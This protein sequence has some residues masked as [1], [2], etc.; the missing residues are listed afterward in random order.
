MAA[1][2]SIRKNPKSGVV[3]KTVS[4]RK[5]L[6]PEQRQRLIVEGAVRFFSEHGL[7]GQLRDLAKS[8]GITHTLMYHYF[9]TK[10]ALIER[11]YTDLFAARWQ[12]EWEVLL[13]DKKLD[14]ETKLTRFYAEYA[15]VILQRDWVRVFVFSGLSDRYIT[16]R[17]FA[18]LGEKLFPRVVRESRKYCGLTLAGKPT[19]RE[20]ELL[21]GLHGSIFYMG[22]RR[23]VYGHGLDDS[24]A[25]DS[26]QGDHPFDQVFIHDRVRGYLLALA[27]LLNAPEKKQTA[28][29]P[30]VRNALTKEVTPWHFH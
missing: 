16:D 10:Q 27:E 18:L 5:R 24:G 14:V 25:A 8:L 19:Q 3:L 7:Q 13:D 26:T 1:V 23:W 22:I 29:R 12:T 30:S 11:V 2:S 4:P 9:P 15:R 6:P 21:F 20:L 28:L 17:Y